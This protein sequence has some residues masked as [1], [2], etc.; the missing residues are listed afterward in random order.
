MR[1][2]DPQPR[3]SVPRKVPVRTYV[4]PHLIRRFH[5]Q[6]PMTGAVSWLLETALVEVLALT[7]GQPAV[8]ELVRNAIRAAILRER[9]AT[10]AQANHAARPQTGVTLERI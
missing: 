10:R 5:D 4:E 9:Q 3:L 8:Q 6:F 7:D 2:I 1:D